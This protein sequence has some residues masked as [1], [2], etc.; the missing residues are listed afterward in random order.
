MDI[1]TLSISSMYP[2]DLTA[3]V[4]A[5]LDGNNKCRLYIND[6]A[7]IEMRRGNRHHSARAAVPLPEWKYD[8]NGTW[9][10][11]HAP[12][13]SRG[14]DGFCTAVLDSV[15]ATASIVRA[16]G[17]MEAAERCKDNGARLIG[18]IESQLTTDLRWPGFIAL[19]S[20]ELIHEITGVNVD[21]RWWG[22]VRYGHQGYFPAD[23]AIRRIIEREGYPR[24]IRFERGGYIAYPSGAAQYEK[25]R[26]IMRIDRGC[27]R[28]VDGKSS[29]GVDLE[30][31][32]HAPGSLPIQFGGS[33]ELELLAMYGELVHLPWYA[34]ACLGADRG[35][36]HPLDSPA[37][38]LRWTPC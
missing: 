26:S 28:L 20:R 15:D 18:A 9:Y 33:V 37:A 7:N 3:A 38:K 17:N 23:M 4:F 29:A 16:A 21:V 32:K 25:Y 12:L 8:T 1:V 14:I 22:S 2:I 36:P 5:L 19:L 6:S 27:Y 34:S 35:G 13:E 10:Q 30:F 31:E 24:K 11:C